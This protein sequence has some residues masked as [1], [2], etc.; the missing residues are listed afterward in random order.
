ME[1]QESDVAIVAAIGPDEE[2]RVEKL[3]DKTSSSGTPHEAAVASRALVYFFGEQ[4]LHGW[5]SKPLYCVTRW[6]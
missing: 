2:E 1:A 5:F 3:L 6:F 4:E